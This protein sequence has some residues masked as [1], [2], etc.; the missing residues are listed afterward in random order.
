MHIDG[1]ARKRVF[2][3]GFP[4]GYYRM[5]IVKYAEEQRGGQGGE[6]IEADN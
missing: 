6:A 5:P 4:V 1:L 3:I 2:V